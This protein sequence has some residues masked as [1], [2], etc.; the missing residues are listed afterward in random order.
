MTEPN[1]SRTIRRA[2]V[3]DDE[4]E[5]LAFAAEA[6]HSFA[7]GFEVATARNLEQADAWLDTFPPDVLLLDRK[8]SDEA[9]GRL[10]PR[11]QADPRTRHCRVIVARSPGYCRNTI[12]R[13]AAP[14]SV[15]RNAPWYVPPRSHTVSPARTRP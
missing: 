12:H 9:A 13:P 3:V 4:E 1:G 6:L 8:F 5:S 15:V 7:P 10:L 2:L 11:L 14:S